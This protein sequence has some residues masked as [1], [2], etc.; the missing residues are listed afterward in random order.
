MRLPI[1]DVTRAR[2]E[3]GWTPRHDALDA[4]LAFLRGL[5]THDGAATPP[6][7]PAAGGPLRAS[8]F[9]TGVGKKP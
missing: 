3:L 1:M 4:M 6:L 9:G 5:R 2:T 7:D 8:E